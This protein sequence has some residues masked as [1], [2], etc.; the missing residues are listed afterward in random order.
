MFTSDDGFPRVQQPASSGDLPPFR[1]S[2]IFAAQ[3]HVMVDDKPPGSGIQFGGVINLY[4]I[5]E[6]VWKG[7][8]ETAHRGAAGIGVLTILTIVGW[9][10]L[11][12]KKL[13]LF[14]APF[15]AVLL[16]TAVAAAWRLD[17][18]YI[19]RGHPRAERI[20]PAAHGQCGR[21]GRED[22]FLSGGDHHGP[23]FVL[24]KGR[25]RHFTST[26]G[27][28]PDV[29]NHSGIAR[30]VSR[31]RGRYSLPLLLHVDTPYLSPADCRRPLGS[32]TGTACSGR[33]L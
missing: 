22:G 17:I 33:L 28:S 8:T 2:G 1:I 18:Q 21:S 30:S 3:F 13:K 11:A 4:T 15:F 6:A 26:T 25:C 10:L 29:H 5:P 23:V 32:S 16:A 9:T 12:P 27:E 19:N 24:M 14:P 7:L 20:E 31:T